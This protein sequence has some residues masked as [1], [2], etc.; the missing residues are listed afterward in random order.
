MMPWREFLANCVPSRPGYKRFAVCRL[1][2]Y[3]RLFLNSSVFIYEHAEDGND[4]TPV[5]KFGWMYKQNTVC[6]S[7]VY[8]FQNFVV[9]VI[10]GRR[11]T[12]SV[13][14]HLLDCNMSFQHH[15][16]A[17]RTLLSHRTVAQSV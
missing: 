7:V 11:I 17:I 13:G 3:L 5:V 12:R 6:S 9:Q 1:G 2:H 4:S 14:T 15:S 10:G 8:L 16:E